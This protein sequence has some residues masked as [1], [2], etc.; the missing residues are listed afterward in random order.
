MVSHTNTNYASGVVMGANGALIINTDV[1][2]PAATVM[3]L[4]LPPIT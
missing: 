4:N 3:Y 1:E 2:T